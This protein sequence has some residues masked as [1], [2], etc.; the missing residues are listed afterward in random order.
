MRISK[1]C[2]KRARQRLGLNKRA[3]KRMVDEDRVP[4][5]YRLIVEN[6]TA[7]TITL[8]LGECDRRTKNKLSK[9]SRLELLKRGCDG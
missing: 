7:I 2:Y 1:H 3:F 6:D 9:Q 5:E 4:I 8:L